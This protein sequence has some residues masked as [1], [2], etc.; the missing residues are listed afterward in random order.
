MILMMIIITEMLSNT[1]C[2]YG[3]KGLGYAGEAGHK[4]AFNNKALIHIKQIHHWIANNA[5]RG[6]SRLAR[7]LKMI[8]ISKNTS[9][10]ED[11]IEQNKE[12]V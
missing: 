5:T 12:S 2:Q 6:Q 11:K 10:G 9:K 7:G 4:F 3:F 1:E 8:N